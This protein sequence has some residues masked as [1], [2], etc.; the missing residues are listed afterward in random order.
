MSHSNDLKY[1]ICHR[2]GV[3]EKHNPNFNL[4]KKPYIKFPTIEVEQK[5]NPGKKIEFFTELQN[6]DRRKKYLKKKTKH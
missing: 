1:Y 2:I 6:N 4:T 5:F 3:T